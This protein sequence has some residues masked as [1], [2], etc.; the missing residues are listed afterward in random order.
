LFRDV[1]LLLIKA[2]ELD[3]QITPQQDAL[4]AM[5]GIEQGLQQSS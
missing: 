5:P 4:K 1:H 2:P 3:P